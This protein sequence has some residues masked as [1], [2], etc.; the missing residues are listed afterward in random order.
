MSKHPLFFVPLVFMLSYATAQAAAVDLPET[1]Q[2]S[3]TDNAGLGIAC[4]NTGQ[5]GDFKAGVAWPDPRFVAGSGAEVDCVT[6]KL[7][8]LM[9]VRAPSVVAGNWT[10]ALA[11]ANDLTLCGFS[12]WRLPNVIEL[13]SMLNGEAANTSTYLN[14][15]GFSGVTAGTY[16]SSTSWTGNA[17]YAY[18]V[19]LN[20]GYLFALTKTD[21]YY[22]WPVRAGQ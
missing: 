8:G 3:C 20:E 17:V 1:G 9:W 12:D 21:S 14:S 11:S 6:D 5:D 2:T 7:T 18:T 15:Q 4:A 10:S 22:I 16:W 13:E 19:N